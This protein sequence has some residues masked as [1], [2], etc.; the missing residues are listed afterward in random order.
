MIIIEDSTL[1]REVYEFMKDADP[2]EYN[3]TV[4][5]ELQFIMEIYEAIRN[6]DTEV[7]KEYLKDFIEEGGDEEDVQ[8]AKEL[9]KELEKG[10][11]NQMKKMNDI[12]GYAVY[13]KVH[14]DSK[15]GY[16]VFVKS[17][18]EKDAIDII[19]RKKLYEDE[20]DL[21][22]IESVDEITEEDILSGYINK[23]WF[24]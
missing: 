2:Y 18:S 8:K 10:E 13:F 22:N 15:T 12:Y 20:E 3:D 6:N 21:D 4:D 19:K 16:S 24:E 11:Q 7:I 9:L 14:N 1:A 23:D 17:D 5:D